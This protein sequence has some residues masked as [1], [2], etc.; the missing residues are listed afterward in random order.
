M[1]QVSKAVHVADTPG[2]GTT[3]SEFDK[4]LSMYSVHVGLCSWAHEHTQL[5]R[6][7]CCEIKK[8]RAFPTRLH[9]SAVDNGRSRKDLSQ[10]TAVKNGGLSL[11][12]GNS[13]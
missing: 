1:K 12:F 4:G 11:I 2:C 7:V 8:R 9:A 3:K 6:P 13:T 10:G 5:P